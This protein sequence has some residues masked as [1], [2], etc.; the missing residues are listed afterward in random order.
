MWSRKFLR[1]FPSKSFSERKIISNPEN[2]SN[3]LKWQSHGSKKE[4]KRA[5]EEH[6]KTRFREYTDKVRT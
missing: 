6:H 5:S 1:K 2:Q 4:C 3:S